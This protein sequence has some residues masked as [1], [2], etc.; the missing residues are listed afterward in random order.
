MNRQPTASAIEINDSV[1]AYIKFKISVRNPHGKIKRATG[2]MS[3]RL[4]EVSQ[5]Q[6]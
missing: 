1:F 5:L 2:N 4:R 6:I 3:Q